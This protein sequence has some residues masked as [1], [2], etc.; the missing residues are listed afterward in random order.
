MNKT[1]VVA[2]GLVLIVLI[3]G[4][5]YASIQKPED[6]MM[7]K[8]M[9]E[10]SSMEE[11]KMMK[12]DTG[13]MDEKES[14]MKGSYESYSAEKLARAESGDVVLFFHA[15]WCPSC[16][17]LN[18]DIEANRDS[19]PEEV[20]ILKVDYDTESELKKKYGVTY[21]HTLVQVAADGTLIK[22]WSG[23]PTLAGALAQII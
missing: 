3:G 11:D 13:M 22:K 5:A 17:G 6:G 18:A 8:K 1:I 2:I 19:I 16:R 20:S 14:M 21:Q 4:V 12:E 10:S 23:S 15:S 7:D 9:Q